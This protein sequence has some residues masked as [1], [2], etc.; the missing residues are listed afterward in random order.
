MLGFVPPAVPVP[1]VSTSCSGVQILTLT[2]LYLCSPFSDKRVALIRKQLSHQPDFQGYTPGTSSP[3]S[4]LGSEVS[5]SV[6]VQTSGN[7]DFPLAKFLTTDL[8]FI[9]L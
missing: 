1:T 6:T 7:A 2:Y 9:F 3:S 5:P 4:I 8:S